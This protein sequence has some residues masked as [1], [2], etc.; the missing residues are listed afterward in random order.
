M[1]GPGPKRRTQGRRVRHNDEGAFGAMPAQCG[2]KIQ[3]LLGFEPQVSGARLTPA[4]WEFGCR[5]LSHP[6]PRPHT[7]ATT[8]VTTTT[9]AATAT[10]TATAT[11]TTRVRPNLCA[12]APSSEAK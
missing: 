2:P 10:T 4:A 12:H 3:E 9:I 1:E 8:A 5:H 7:T 6:H 11:A